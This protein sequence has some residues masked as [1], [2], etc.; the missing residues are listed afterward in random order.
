[1][2]LN[3]KRDDFVLEDFIRCGELISLKKGRAREIVSDVQ[4]VVS[5][6]PTYA[7]QANMPED[8]TSAI[9]N[10]HRLELVR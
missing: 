10:S 9:S 5:N 8:Q 3:S 2:T 6:W 1:M 7:E 4:E